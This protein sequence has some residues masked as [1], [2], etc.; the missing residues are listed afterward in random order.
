M[1]EDLFTAEAIAKWAR[2][3]KDRHQETFLDTAEYLAECVRVRQTFDMEARISQ[4]LSVEH[5]IDHVRHGA[6]IPRNEDSE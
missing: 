6:R 1:K 4:G 3:A 5:F 2:Q